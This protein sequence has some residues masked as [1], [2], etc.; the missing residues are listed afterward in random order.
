MVDPNAADSGQIEDEHPNGRCNVADPYGG[1]V[2]SDGGGVITRVMKDLALKAGKNLFT[3]N[4]AAITGMSTPAF[5]HTTKSYL[6]TV[7][8]EATHLEYYARKIMNEKP[9]PIKKIQSIV[10]MSIA[11]QHYGPT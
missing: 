11:N 8:Y 7:P 9:N 10:A 4:L 2:M 3:G 1:I 5:I 6:D